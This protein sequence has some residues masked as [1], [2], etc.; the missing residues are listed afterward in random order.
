MVEIII[1]AF[2]R[3]FG[4]SVRALA[5]RTAFI[6]AATKVAACNRNP[7]IG[8]EAIR[9]ETNRRAQ[10]YGAVAARCG[11]AAPARHGAGR[12]RGSH[13]CR[14]TA[15][16]SPAACGPRYGKA[17]DPTDRNR[18]DV[19]YAGSGRRN[20]GPDAPCRTVRASSSKTRRPETRPARAV[21][22]CGADHQGGTIYNIVRVSL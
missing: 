9:E 6:E 10:A 4:E 16:R 2:G 14:H 13:P 12:T 8:D 7:D 19:P 21:S 18:S 15:V 20:W 11:K 17:P 22:N 5:P 3:V 1:S